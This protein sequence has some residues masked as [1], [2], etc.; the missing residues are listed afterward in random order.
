MYPIAQS[1]SPAVFAPLRKHVRKTNSILRIKTSKHTPIIYT[2]N[3]HTHQGKRQQPKQTSKVECKARR[4]PDSNARD[5]LH[6]IQT[7]AHEPCNFHKTR[8]E[9]KTTTDNRARA[10]STLPSHSPTLRRQFPNVSINFF[11]PP[12]VVSFRVASEKTLLTRFPRLP[13]R[14]FPRTTSHAVPPLLPRFSVPC[15]LSSTTRKRRAGRREMRPA[16]W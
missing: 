11:S 12:V 4:A 1:K 3:T 8:T 9:N 6:F 14:T 16:A 7:S 10:F 2:E 15:V 13:R 5:S